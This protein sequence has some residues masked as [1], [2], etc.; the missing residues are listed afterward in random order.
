VIPE[1]AGKMT[2]MSFRV[3]VP[4]VSVCDLTVRLSSDAT[5]DEICEEIKHRA[6]T[7]MHGILGYEDDPL[8]SQ[9]FVGDIRSSIFDA[10]AG[11]SLENSRLVKLVAWYDNE[12]GYSMRMLDLAEYVAKT[13]RLGDEGG[14]AGHAGGKSAM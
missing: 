12:M 9:D 7:D 6:N 4:N 8:V 2:G 11:L 14:A 10:T 13:D 5:Y 1:L 3:P